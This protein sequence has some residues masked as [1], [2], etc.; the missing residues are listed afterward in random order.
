MKIVRQICFCLFVTFFANLLIILG[1][2]AITR[3]LEGYTSY[4]G[5]SVVLVQSDSMQESQIN[6]NSKYLIHKENSYEVGDIVVFRH[7][8]SFWLHEIVEVS[9][10][11]FQTKGSS[12]LLNDPFLITKKDIKGKYTGKCLDSVIPGLP[13]AI[14]V[15]DWTLYMLYSIFAI[16]QILTSDQEPKCGPNVSL[17]EKAKIHNERVDEAEK[18]KKAVISLLLVFVLFTSS[19]IPV[20]AANTSVCQ[21]TGEIDYIVDTW[22]IDPYIIYSKNGT[23]SGLKYDAILADNVRSLNIE[24]T[25]GGV[26]ITSIDSGVFVADMPKFFEIRLPETITSVHITDL[27]SISNLT[28]TS[29]IPP[30]PIYDGPNKSYSTRNRNRDIFFFYPS[31]SREQYLNSNWKDYILYPS[32]FVEY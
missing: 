25:W 13:I 17:K 26:T 2:G 16:I 20:R 10:D 1:Y 18:N 8:N 28:F 21:L 30:E 32:Q 22:P 24:K 27:R 14:F 19:N 15:I 6:K 7:N 11:K 31:A 9:G 3:Y 4:F 12:N 29:S 5:Y 23:V